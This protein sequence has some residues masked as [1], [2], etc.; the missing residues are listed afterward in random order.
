MIGKDQPTTVEGARLAAMM[1]RKELVRC[2][3]DEAAVEILDMLLRD[4]VGLVD[5]ATEQPPVV[6]R[7][8]QCHVDTGRNTY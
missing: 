4:L 3:D 7:A 2:D 6:E 1:R 5:E 8:A